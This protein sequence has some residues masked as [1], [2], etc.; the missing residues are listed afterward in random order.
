MNQ[1]FR[2][3]EQISPTLHHHGLWILHFSNAMKIPFSVK[4]IA[5][6]SILL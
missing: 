5:F 6:A 1:F 2:N 3:V 4:K